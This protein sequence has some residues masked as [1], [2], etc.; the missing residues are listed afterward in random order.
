MRVKQRNIRILDAHVRLLS[1]ERSATQE[2][3]KPKVMVDIVPVAASR[4]LVIVNTQP[5]T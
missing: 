2:T 4:V 1:F 3:V 5:I